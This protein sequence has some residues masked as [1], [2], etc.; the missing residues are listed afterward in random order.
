MKTS[1]D[2]ASPLFQPTLP[3]RTDPTPNVPDYLQQVY[4]WAY[5]HPNAVRLFE[6]EWLVNLILWG[7]FNRLRDAALVE[8]GTSIDHAVLQIACVYGD[9]TQRIAA[10]LGPLGTLDVVDVAPIQ[11]HNLQGKLD[12]DQRIAMHLQ[13]AS[14]LRLGDASFETALLFFLLHEQPDAVRR[15]TLSEALRV[16]KPGG[17]VVIV[18]YHRPHRGHPLRYLMAPVLRMLEPFALDLWQR[19]ITDYLPSDALDL[20]RT[21]TTYFGGLYQKLVLQL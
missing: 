18:D 21:K 19:E 14:T 16:T 11:L 4:W 5:L 6:R 17:K 3:A 2:S 8:L 20:P 10:R 15:A 1:A 9:F 7:N 13:D 12:P